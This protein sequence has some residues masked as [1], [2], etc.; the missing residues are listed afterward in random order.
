[1]SMAGSCHP[2]PFDLYDIE[3][4]KRLIR[5]LAGYM[6]VSLFYGKEEVGL[7]YAS[8]AVQRLHEGIEAGDFAI[9]RLIEKAPLPFVFDER[10][11][12]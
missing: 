11:E 9:V 7:R 3:E 5:E 12:S 2:K 4:R 8:D 10:D 1:M 6:K